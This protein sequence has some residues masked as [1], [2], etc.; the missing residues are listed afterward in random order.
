MAVTSF[1]TESPSP[2][3]SMLGPG[4]CRTSAEHDRTEPS[5]C[6]NVNLYDCRFSQTTPT[7]GFNTA[8][9]AGIVQSLQMFG[10][11]IENYTKAITVTAGGVNLFGVYF[12]TFIPSPDQDNGV[13]FYNKARG[14][15]WCSL[16]GCDLPPERD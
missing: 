13:L 2:M 11:S 1:A 12:E 5:G 7:Q 14:S 16:D 3:P 9:V 15:L 8:I 6:Y 10:G 4:P